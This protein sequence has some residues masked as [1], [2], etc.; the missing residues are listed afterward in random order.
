LHPLKGHKLVEN[1][2]LVRAPDP[3]AAGGMLDNEILVELAKL[4]GNLPFVPE[5]QVRANR[6]A[7]Y[8]GERNATVDSVDDLKKLLDFATVVATGC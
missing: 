7:V 2:L 3:A 6:V 8:L 5:I 1:N 4:A